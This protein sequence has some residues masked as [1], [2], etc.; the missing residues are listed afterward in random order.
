MIL[1]FTCIIRIHRTRAAEFVGRGL[2]LCEMADDIKKLTKQSIIIIIIIIIP[3]GCLIFRLRDLSLTSLTTE[4]T[5][6]P[7]ETDKCRYN[8]HFGIQRWQWNGSYFVFYLWYFI[9]CI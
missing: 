1:I 6:L 7:A 3:D 9:H 2:S 8:T 4:C 5:D